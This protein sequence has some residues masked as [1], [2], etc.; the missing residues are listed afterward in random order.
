MKSIVVDELSCFVW[1]LGMPASPKV[2]EAESAERVH[3]ARR[4]SDMENE[5]ENLKH[6]LHD[7]GQVDELM[8]RVANCESLAGIVCPVK[9]E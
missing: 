7:N 4:I 2:S 8:Q 5:I 9:E 1:C 3:L 6:R